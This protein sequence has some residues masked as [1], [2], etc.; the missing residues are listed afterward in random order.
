MERITAADNLI[1]ELDTE[2]WRLLADGL[3]GGSE[4]LL[5][6]AESG[7]PARYVSAFA[8]R[9]KLPSSGTL[10]P[11][12]IERI[13]LGWSEKDAAWHLGL[14]LDQPLAD[15]RGSRW[16]GLATW[17]DPDG[18]IFREVAGHAGQSLAHKLA[19]PFA[20]VPPKPDVMQ[21]VQG[22][23]APVD[24]SEVRH[25][26]PQPELPLKFDHWSLQSV[27]GHGVALILSPSWARSRFVRA[28]WYISLMGVFIVLTLTTLTSGIA[29]PRPEF[30]VYLGFA[31][32]LIMALAALITLIGAALQPKRIV[33]DGAAGV[34]VWMRG[35]SVIRQIPAGMI[36]EI[37]VS[38]VVS[39]VGK[40][41][42]REVRRVRHGELNL[43][44]NDNAFVQ[45]LVQA[46][47]E[48]TIPVTD[49]PL[50]EETVSP[51]TV[52]NARTRLQS[53]ALAI[54]EIMHVSA[55]YDKRL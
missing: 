17:Q 39:R 28:G 1:I 43:L 44:L 23:T 25:P 3:S 16:C 4:R 12:R 34:V 53:A 55:T 2:R 37:Y 51:L 8:A 52:F 35:R 20:L 40:W 11:D 41:A 48:E 19:R 5:F 54:A 49:D 38:Q 22:M 15:E 18:G 36:R 6:E 24:T 14:V 10:N 29:F 47:T 42:D 21:N 27:S 26:I 30:L 7:G 31:S 9:R 50:D 13:V 45:L 46:R 32:I 33:F